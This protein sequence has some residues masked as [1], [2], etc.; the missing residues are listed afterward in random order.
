MSDDGGVRPRAR[1][2]RVRLPSVVE[3][4]PAGH[5]D[6]EPV[7]ARLERRS[8]HDQVQRLIPECVRRNDR[9]LEQARAVPV[10]AQPVVGFRLVGVN[11]EIVGERDDCRAGRARRSPVA[12]G[13]P[14]RKPRD[15]LADPRIIGR[16]LHQRRERVRGGLDVVTEPALRLVRPPVEAGA[17]LLRARHDHVEQLLRLFLAIEFGE[18]ARGERQARR[19][20]A[21]ARLVDECGRLEHLRAERAEA[22]RRVGQIHDRGEV[23]E[24][25]GLAVFAAHLVEAALHAVRAVHDRALGAGAVAELR[26]TRERVECQ[27]GEVGIELAFAPPAPAETRPGSSPRSAR[28]REARSPESARTRPAG[29]SDNPAAARIAREEYLRD[30]PPV[31]PTTPAPRGRCRNGRRTSQTAPATSTPPSVHRRRGVVPPRPR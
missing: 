13:A 25:V 12:A 18:S 16:D 8:G 29:R 21:L 30:A 7:V 5:G 6:P 4:A 9:A 31:R 14:R 11:A 10:D 1:H 19:A 27:G 20:Q 22:L 28:P 23:G 24:D 3:A 15:D 26:D 2:Q 17:V